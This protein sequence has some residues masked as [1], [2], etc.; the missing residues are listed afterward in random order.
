M[1][2]LSFVVGLDYFMISE[3]EEAPKAAPIPD[4]DFS[5]MFS[6]FPI[7]CFAYQAHLS[8]V[9]IYR[10]I[11]RP[12]MFPYISALALFICFCLYNCK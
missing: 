4:P 11:E 6:T 12:K 10:R 7:F 1:V 2:V 9:K 5:T 8:S 3:L